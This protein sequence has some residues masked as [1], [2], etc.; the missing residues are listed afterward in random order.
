MPFSHILLTLLVVL[1]WGINFLF[2][3][4]GLQEIPPLF[5]CTLRFTLSSIPAIFFIKPPE[6]P[7]KIVVYYG[8]VMFAMQFGLV[9]TGMQVG[10]TA[11]M[12]SLIMQVQVFFSM[13]MAMYFLGEKVTISQMIGALIGFMGIGVV[14]LHFDN[15]VSFLGFI[16]ILGA[17]TTWGVGNLITK[18]VKSANLISLIVWGTFVAIFPVFILSLLLEGPTQI[19]DTYHHIT[20][21][22]VGALMYIVYASTWV[23]YG[24]W[25]WLLERYPVSMVVPFTLLIPVV[26]LVSSVLFMGEPFQSWKLVAGLLIISGLCINLISSRIFAIKTQ[27]AI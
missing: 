8:L 27:E 25:N 22:G 6:A 11:G 21:R 15:N 16:L 14:A 12:A 17:A 1:V 20:W 4:I 26:G 2:V 3:K 23:G 19:L 24:V 9:F 18:Q 13:F 7:F 10:M 5:L